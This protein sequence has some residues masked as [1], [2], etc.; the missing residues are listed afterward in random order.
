MKGTAIGVVKYG[1]SKVPIKIQLYSELKVQLN[2]PLNVQLR[3]REK[4]RKTAD[5]GTARG[6][7]KI[8]VRYLAYLCIVIKN[9]LPNCP[10]LLFSKISFQSRE[11]PLPPG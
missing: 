4:F 3:I 10:F 1:Y 9:A 11:S 5:K 2:E 7:L 6:W 8:Q